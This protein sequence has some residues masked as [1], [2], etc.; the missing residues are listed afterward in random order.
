MPKTVNFPLRGRG[1]DR[2]LCSEK[3]AANKC[4]LASLHR[5]PD[6]FPHAIASTGVV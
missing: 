4:G 2:Q 5:R 3:V 6:R 1:G